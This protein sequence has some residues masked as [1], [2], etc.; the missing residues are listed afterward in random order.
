M[1]ALFLETDH[2]RR[3]TSSSSSS[4]LF[5]YAAQMTGQKTPKKK[6]GGN[7]KP[8]KARLSG[9][10]RLQLTRRTLFNLPPPVSLL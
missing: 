7:E 3:R 1:N 5:T 9:H 2:D 8:P 10:A 4:C 6:W